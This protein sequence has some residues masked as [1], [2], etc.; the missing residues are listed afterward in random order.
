MACMEHDC[1]TPGCKGSQFNNRMRADKPCPLC[2]GRLFHATS[3]EESGGRSCGSR[4]VNV[5]KCNKCAK[6]HFNGS[7]DPTERCECGGV[8]FSSVIEDAVGPI[9]TEFKK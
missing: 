7:E 9:Q 1:A 2:G 5:H 6:E 3:D 8:E 4:Y